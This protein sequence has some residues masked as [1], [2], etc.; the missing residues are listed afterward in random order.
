MEIERVSTIHNLYLHRRSPRELCFH[1]LDDALNPAL[2]AHPRDPSCWALVA[3]PFQF[4]L[5]YALSYGFGTR[6]SPEIKER[7]FMIVT[8]IVAVIYVVVVQLFLANERRE[9]GAC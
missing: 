4:L 3:A 5:F 6:L 7:L 9:I 1:R 8:F 2:Q